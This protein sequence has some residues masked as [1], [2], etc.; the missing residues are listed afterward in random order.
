MRSLKIKSMRN[1]VLVFFPLVG[2]AAVTCVIET[3]SYFLIRPISLIKHRQVCTYFSRCFFLCSTFLLE[4]WSGITF[5]SYGDRIDPKRS[6]LTV[7][8]HRSDVDWL[9]GLAYVAH[10]GMPYPGN[11]KSAVKASLGKV[12]L[13]GTILNYAEFLFLTRDWSTDRNQ[14]LSALTSLRSYGKSGAPL[15]F[16]LYPE[17]TRFTHEKCEYS[18]AYAEKNNLRPHE[19]VLFPRFKAFTAIVSTLRNE[20]DGI[21]DA[22][23]MFEGEQ[24]TVKATFAGTASTVVHVHSR[25][26]PMKDIP[27]GEEKLE[28]WLLDRWYEKDNRLGEFLRDNDTLGPPAAGYSSISR[29]HSVRPFYALVAAYAFFS[30]VIVY[31][32]SKIQN[33]LLFLFGCSFTAVTMT[34]IF[35][36]FNLKPSRKGSGRSSS[37]K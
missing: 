18:R 7:V 8:N 36:V 19:H 1:T 31:R 25:Y 12:P 27:E 10:F 20:F 33:G 2:A 16:V 17:G 29:P 4:R 11:A 22:T 14:F 35:V 24:P 23:F 34:A 26:Y 30:A 15:W 5:K 21:I 13:F 37:R 28:K 6:Y 3:L 32:L 9:L